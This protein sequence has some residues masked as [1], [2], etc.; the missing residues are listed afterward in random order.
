MKQIRCSVALVLL[1]VSI[2]AVL[3]GQA[4]NVNWINPLGGD[5]S[6]AANWNTNGGPGSNDIAVLPDLGGSYTVNLDA[7]A[8]VS[9]LVVGAG[10]GAHT[11]T[12]TNGSATL[13]VNGVIEVNSRGIFNLNGGTITGTYGLAGAMTCSLG[14]YLEGI[15]TVSNNAVLNLAGAY[16]GDSVV[17]YGT[18]LT[19]Y[20]TVNWL[21][22]GNT[23][24]YGGSDIP[25]NGTVICNFGLWNALSDNTFY[26]SGFPPGG[27]VFNNL[28]TLRKSGTTG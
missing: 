18:T 14:A 24:L 8:T 3:P 10:S 7:D 1:A 6:G 9:G 19:N 4:G 15:M 26:G 13:T 22:T 5:W 11:Q 2:L 27:T 12:F 17:L 25:G 28:G 21:N 23:T 16:D 20:G